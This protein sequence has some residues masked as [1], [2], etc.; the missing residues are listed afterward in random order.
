MLAKILF[1][2]LEFYHL[3]QYFTLTYYTR[4]G[5]WAVTFFLKYFENGDEEREYVKIFA[6]D[7]IAPSQVRCRLGLWWPLIGLWTVFSASRFPVVFGTGIDRVVPVG[8]SG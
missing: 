6:V 5:T 4:Q 2:C 1:F 8:A 7:F 3:F